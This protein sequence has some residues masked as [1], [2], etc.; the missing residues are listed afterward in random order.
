MVKTKAEELAEQQKEISVSQFFEKN[1][2]LLGFDNPLRAL[3]TAVKELVDNSL[4]ATEEMQVLPD[5]KVEIKQ[6]AE[7]RF[8]VSVFDNGP[9]IVKEQIPKVFAKL[10]YGSKFGRNCQGRGQQGIGVSASLL[11]GQLTTGKAAKITSKIG[12][13][14]PAHYYELKIDINKNEPQILR[15]QIVDLPF[16]HGTKVVIELEGKYQKGRQGVDEYLKQVAIA[17]PHVEII[18]INPLKEKIVFKRAVTKLPKEPKSIKPHPYGVEIGILMRMLS[19]SRAKTLQGFFANE[20]SR[21][22]SNLARQ[23]CEKV[24]V[25]YDVKPVLVNHEQCEKLIKS[26]KETKISSPP[27]DCLSPIG[28]KAIVEGLKKEIKGEFYTAISRRPSVYRGYPFLIEVG[29][30]YGGEL[31]ADESIRVIRLANKVPLQYQQSACAITKSVINTSWRNY[32]LSQSKGALPTGPILLM[33]HIASVWV[34]FTSEAKEAIAHYPEIIKQVKL[35]LQDIGRKLGSYIR[36]TVKVKEQQE[37]VNLFERY[38][39]EL[40]NSLSS[41]TG[42]KKEDITKDLEKIFKKTLKQNLF[43]IEN[44]KKEDTS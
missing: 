3:S 34:P 15:D 28:E 21:V 19:L 30:V 5:V 27:L 42:E 40:A 41:L 4:D 8:E 14:K 26:I 11:Y 39:P 23:I 43:E 44:D 36:K 35:A 13:N 10:L 12:K 22:S 24:Q 20:F 6:I 9:G 33:V 25:P 17:N 1:R 37:R 2:H 16:D 29:L 32:G 7:T 18:Y 31:L 38:I